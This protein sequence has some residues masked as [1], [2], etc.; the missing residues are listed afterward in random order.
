[1]K[2]GKAFN[3]TIFVSEAGDVSGKP[4]LLKTWTR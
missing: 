2:P 1:M 3:D 4:G